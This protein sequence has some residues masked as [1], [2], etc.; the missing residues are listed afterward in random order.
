M[1]QKELVV[2]SL[3]LMFDEEMVDTSLNIDQSSWPKG[4]KEKKQ[5]DLLPSEKN[6]LSSWDIHSPF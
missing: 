5:W 4:Q 2:F 6:C 3:L 1:F